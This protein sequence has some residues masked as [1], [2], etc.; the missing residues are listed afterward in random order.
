MNPKKT[1]N[2]NAFKTKIRNLDK[3]GKSFQFK[4]P[5]RRDT[6]KSW[7]G[8]AVTIIV[9]MLLGSYGFL[10]GEKLL[11]FGDSRTNASLEDSAFDDTEIWSTG[12]GLEFAFAITDFDDE[13]ESIEDPSYGQL[14]AQYQEWGLE[15]LHGN[16][17]FPIPLKSCSHEDLGL[18][19]A[20]ASTNF[21]PLHRDSVYHVDFYARKFKCFDHERIRE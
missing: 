6:F 3:F 7:H 17:F 15:N 18:D 12:N 11:F 13:Q 2:L 8:L 5:D 4:F 10:K 1:N 21:Y 16:G 14:L 20:R 9:Y 19:E